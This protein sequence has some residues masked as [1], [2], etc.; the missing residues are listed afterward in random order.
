V[1]R[2]LGWSHLLRPK[3]K[4]KKKTPVEGK[5]RSLGRF[6]DKCGTEV[7]LRSPLAKGNGRGSWAGAGPEVVQSASME[8]LGSRRTNL[9]VP[10]GIGYEGEGSKRESIWHW[11]GQATLGGAALSLQ[12]RGEGMGVQKNGVERFVL[13][14]CCLL[15]FLRGGNGGVS[16]DERSRGC[17]LVPRL[18]A[19]LR[20][21]AVRFAPSG[22]SGNFRNGIAK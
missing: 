19:E 17:F 5:N 10:G 12:H 2:L 16:G 1:R 3:R 14:E 15:V 22:P 21:S 18:C 13:V 11:N 20:Q 6:E 8:S 7:R 4:G 9:R